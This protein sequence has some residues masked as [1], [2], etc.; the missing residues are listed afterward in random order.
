MTG[1]NGAKQ[2]ARADWYFTAASGQNYTNE[3][4][5]TAAA[6]ASAQ[7]LEQIA[8]SLS[9]ILSQLQFLGHDGIH[10][11]IR[12]EAQRVRRARKVAAGKRRARRLAKKAREAQS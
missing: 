2:I 10:D 1:R 8:R 11:V 9:S 5:L 3:T 6:V 7:Y 12:H 4:I